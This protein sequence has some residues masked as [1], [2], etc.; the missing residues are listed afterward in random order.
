[1]IISTLSNSNKTIAGFN[2]EFI[3]PIIRKYSIILYVKIKSEYQKEIVKYNIQNVILDY[4][5]NLSYSVKFISKSDIINLILNNDTDKLIES[6]DLTFISE[7]NEMAFAEGTY[8]EYINDDD[9]YTNNLTKHKYKYNNNNNLGLDIFGNISLNTIIE[10][11]RLCGN[12]KY[13][14]DKEN[15]NKKDGIITKPIEIYFV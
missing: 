2:I 4:F 9:F 8:E 3:N 12:I 6:I 15:S 14:I 13:Y 10:I 5:L 7:Y 11:P 1:M